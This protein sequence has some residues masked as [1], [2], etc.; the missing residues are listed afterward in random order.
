MMVAVDTL[1][2]KATNKVRRTSSV[3]VSVCLFA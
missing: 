2:W 3:C 1:A